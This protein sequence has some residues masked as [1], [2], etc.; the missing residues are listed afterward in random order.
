V[1]GQFEMFAGDPEGSVSLLSDLLRTS[2]RV[3][4]KKLSNNDRDW[5]QLPNKHQA[6]VYIR[7]AERD[8]GFFPALIEKDRA[9]GGAAIREC[10]FRTEWP[11]AGET[12][13]RTRLVNYT[14]KGAETHMT[15]LPKAAFATLSPASLLVIGRSSEPGVASFRCLTIE[16]TSEDALVLADTLGLD[17]NFVAGIFDPATAVQE[18][19][20][21][22]LDYAA[23]VVAAWLGGTIAAFANDVAAMPGTLELATM[24]RQK[25]LAD[26]QLVKLSPFELDRPGDAVRDISRS[27]EWDLFREFQRRERAVALVRTILGDTPVELNAARVIRSLVDNIGEVDRLMLSASQQRKSRAG[28]SFEHQIEAM[29]IDGGIP[30][31]KQ[32]IMDAKKR[33][34][35]ILPF[36]RQFQNP[37]AGSAPGL[38]LSAKTTLRERWKQVQR[39]MAGGDL[40]LATVDETIAANAIEDMASLGIVLVVPEALKSSNST[41]YVRHSNVIGF[42][43]FFR[44]ELMGKRMRDWPLGG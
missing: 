13:E 25:Y 15:R 43:D 39:E 21:T 12:Q 8:S 22:I 36:L 10:Y 1:A 35:F 41:E 32:V 4:V 23:Q 18:E 9:E 31:A 7:P 20:A 27:V 2:E 40:F 3:F 14:S 44:G 30:F 17:A 11:Q 38:I 42:G 34:D 16:S 29:L 37:I 26:H 28:Y 33:P 6:G 19:R 24:A 5:A